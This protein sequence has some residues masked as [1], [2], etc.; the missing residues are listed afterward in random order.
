MAT[1]NADIPALASTIGADVPDI[2]ENFQELHDVITAITNGTLGTTE[3]ASFKVDVLAD[4]SVDSAH[5]ASNA[6]ETAKI[7]D[8]NVTKAKIN[9]DVVGTGLAGGAGTALS[10]DGIVEANSDELK[11][12]IVEIGTWNMD[13]T[14]SV[15]IAH[16]LTK[17][18]IRTIGAVIRS[19]DDNETYPVSYGGT[20][21]VGAGSEFVSTTIIR[22]TRVTGGSFDNNSFDIMGDDGNRGW[23]TIWYVA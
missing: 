1:W 7:K 12:K 4:E 13:T 9:A 20:D 23:I 3:P 16:G 8:A 21:G 10:V 2:E 17:G 11:V 22:L 5:L 18:K 6:V 19:D 14:A 15:D